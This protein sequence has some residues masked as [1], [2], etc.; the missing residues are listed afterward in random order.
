MIFEVYNPR[1]QPLR[2]VRLALWPA[3]WL[4]LRP[5]GS[6]A[7]PFYSCRRW[8]RRSSVDLDGRLVGH[9]SGSVAPRLQQLLSRQDILC[10]DTT[11]ICCW[12]KTPPRQV[13]HG[14]L[15]VANVLALGE[16]GRW[17]AADAG[18]WDADKSDSSIYEAATALSGIFDV[19]SY[20][21]LK[22][23]P[24]VWMQLLVT[25]PTL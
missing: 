20:A 1:E 12:N 19:W 22:G 15:A 21:S 18:D 14:Y 5:H 9:N 4:M 16:P 23:R 7:A 2:T 10:V 17:C 24:L 6:P 11:H 13:L 8:R 3:C 25:R